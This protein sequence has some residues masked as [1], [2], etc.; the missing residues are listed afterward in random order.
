MGRAILATINSFRNA[1]INKVF[2]LVDLDYTSAECIDLPGKDPVGLPIP[3][4][5]QQI[6]FAG[7]SPAHGARLLLRFIHHF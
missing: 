1:R 5:V 4:L 3:D 7:T 2:H 6:K